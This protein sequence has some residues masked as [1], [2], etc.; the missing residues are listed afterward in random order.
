MLNAASS[1]GTSNLRVRLGVGGTPETTGYINLVG[2]ISAA[3]NSL[4]SAT[5]GFDIFYGDATYALSGSFEIL[6]LSG[7]IWTFQG[8]A[9]N[10]TT[11]GY[12]AET[13]GVKSL[14]GVLDLIRLTTVS[15][16]TFDAGSANIIYE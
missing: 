7:N 8:K 2:G 16:D 5:A 13:S 10:V 6:N 15:G 11:A 14:A 1:G 3:S 12:F 9:G 4:S